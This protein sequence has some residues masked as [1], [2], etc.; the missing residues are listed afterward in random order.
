VT[1]RRRRLADELGRRRPDVADP[2]AAIASGRVRVDGRVVTNPGSLVSPAASIRV[3]VARA[4]RGE[5]KLRPALAAFGVDVSGR[6]CLDV[7]AAAG[8]FTKVLL[9][10]G[11]SRVYAVDAGHGQLIGSLRRD[12]RVVNLESTNVSELGPALIG[13]PIEVVVV[14]VSYL[15]LASAVAQL[16]P[17]RIAPGAELVGLVKPMFELRLGSAPG[18]R[19]SLDDALAEA[20]RGVQRAGWSVVGWM[21]SPVKGARGAAELL[22]HA[23]RPGSE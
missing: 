14:D 7:G 19:K 5:A 22:L 1:V 2:L 12:E 8:G 18:T 4:L 11:A 16:A 21:D 6:V 17:M 9:E 10:E 3:A 20:R 15:S 23:R 13:E